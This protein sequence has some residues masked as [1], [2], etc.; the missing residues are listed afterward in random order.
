MYIHIYIYIYTGVDVGPPYN[1]ICDWFGDLHHLAR[2][3]PERIS[4]VF[5]FE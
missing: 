3:N 1:G 5:A 4:I 2:R